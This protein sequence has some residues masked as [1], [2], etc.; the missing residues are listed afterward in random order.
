MTL[1]PADLNDLDESILTY[2]KREGRAS[3][4]LFKRA[5]GAEQS[6]QYVSSRFVRLGE[7]GHIRDLYDTGVYELVDDPRD[8]P[9]G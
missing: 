1:D 8:D 6:R 9:S 3:P 5:T 4:M 2:L 7:H